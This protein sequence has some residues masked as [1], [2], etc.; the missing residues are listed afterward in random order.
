MKCHICGRETGDVCTYC[1]EPTCADCAI[2]YTQFNLYEYTV[3]PECDNKRNETLYQIAKIQEMED[4]EREAARIL[5]N[6]KARLRFSRQDFRPSIKLIEGGNTLELEFVDKYEN[7]VKEIYVWDNDE[8]K[9]TKV[10]YQQVNDTS[11]LEA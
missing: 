5:R 7:I 10:V 2:P 9:W 4:K 6:K 3:C 8:K 1:R 11:E